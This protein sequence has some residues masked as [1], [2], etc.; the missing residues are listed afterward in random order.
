MGSPLSP[1]VANMFMEAFE[2]RALDTIE[3]KPKVWLRYVDDVFVIWNH[4]KSSLQSFLG[5]LNNQH[6]NI[7]FTLEEEKDRKIPFL[8]VLVERSQ[9]KLYTSVH[10]KETHTNRY[11]NFNSHHHRRTLTGVIKGLKQRAER[12]CHPSKRYQEM[13]RLEE[14]FVA[15]D[16]PRI[17]VK[18]V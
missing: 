4:G 6:R 8:D 15:N 16:Y 10:R 9:S 3:K 17:L 12:I 5:H 1:I 13:K 2:D 11:I 14:V 7:K 18:K